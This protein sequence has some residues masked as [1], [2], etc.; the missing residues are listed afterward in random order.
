MATISK[1]NWQFRDPG[2][3]IPDGATITGGNFM[4]AVP[5]TEILVGKAITI[6]GGNWTNVKIQPEWT[7]EIPIHNKSFCTNL[8]PDLKAH[9]PAVDHCAENC[10]HVISTEEIWADDVL[11][12]T[13]YTYKHQRIVD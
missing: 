7:V 11:V 6:R 1:G 9:I 10:Q 5:D 13:V 4:Q 12:D 3:D 2:D 8:R